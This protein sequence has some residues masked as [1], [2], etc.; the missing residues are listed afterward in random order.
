MKRGNPPGVANRR[1]FRG[2]GA[3]LP[4]PLGRELPFRRPGTWISCAVVLLVSVSAWAPPARAGAFPVSR[5]VIVTG[6]S[7]GVNRTEADD[8]VVETLTEADVAP[9][10]IVYPGTENVTMGVRTAGNFSAD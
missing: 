6:T 3:S 2:G 1:P 7:D 9:D 5:E 4:G 10:P 8:G